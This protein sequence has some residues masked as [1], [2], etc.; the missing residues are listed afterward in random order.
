MQVANYGDRF[1]AGNCGFKS[2]LW[3]GCL[4]LFSVVRCQVA[5]SATGRSP[6]QSSTDCC[7]S[8]CGPE[9]STMR[10]PGPTGGGGEGGAVDP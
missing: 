9:T 10:R 1:F 7:V 3:H 6:F 8:E 4:S 5:V 2:R